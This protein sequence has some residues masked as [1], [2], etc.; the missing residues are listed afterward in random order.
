MP[1]IE[2]FR[3][4]RYADRLADRLGQLIAPPYDVISPQLQEELY[5]RDP[6]NFVRLEQPDGSS[7]EGRYR[8]AA[9]RLGAWIK[10]GILVQEERPAFY[11]Y[12]QEFPL[13]EGVWVPEPR[14]G[15]RRRALFAA[16]ELVPWGEGVYPH[17]RTLA[18]PKADRL[19]MIETTQANLS[20]VFG[21]LDDP[22][23]RMEEQLRRRAEETAPLVEFS[24]PDGG[25]HRLWR[26]ESPEEVAM[27]RSELTGPIVVADGHHRY[28]TALAYAQAH[29]SLSPEDPRRFVLMGLVSSRSDALLI[30]PI[31]RV[32]GGIAEPQ[33]E[34]LPF[35]LEEIAS[36]TSFAEGN[37]EPVLGALRRAPSSA[38]AF[39]ARPWGYLLAVLRSG[40]KEGV[41]PDRLEVVQ[42]HRSI[43]HGLLGV[44]TDD[45]AA[46]E[47]VVYTVRVDEAVERVRSRA[48][49]LAVFLRPLRVADVLEI[50][51]AGET[52]PQKSTYFYP[53]LPSGLVFRL[54][55][56]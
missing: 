36:L 38:W 16:V 14:A 11:L 17:E 54:L 27:L 33:V 56:S 47:R 5:R 29:G 31:H 49:D 3:G 42:L 48:A 26:I 9:E 18:A 22:E 25:R 2:P 40:E 13:P 12:E 21:I 8:Q 30:L 39:Y 1:R 46:Q 52:M 20:P 32:L 10:E 45:P 50:A 53:K 6:Y 19:R 41:G 44:D 37:P 15:Y 43:L 55:G 23:G 4:I 34:R 7:G 28:E 35:L 24:D 51:Y